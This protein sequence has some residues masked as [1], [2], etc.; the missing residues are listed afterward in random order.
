MPRRKFV[1]IK[2]HG[3]P[4]ISKYEAHFTSEA[5]VQFTKVARPFPEKVEQKWRRQMGR[6]RFQPKGMLAMPS[7][8]GENDAV[9]ITCVLDLLLRIETDTAI[10]PSGF[11]DLLNEE[12]GHLVVFDP[13][14]VGR[15]FTGLLD[16]AQDA[17]VDR[18]AH[19]Q[20]PLDRIMESGARLLAVIDGAVENRWWLGN[21]RELMGRKAQRDIAEVQQGASPPRS[22]ATWLV[23]E[24]V[25]FAVVAPGQDEG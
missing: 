22:E 24:Q 10:H 19:W 3:R 20:R 9:S 1:N 2:R 12:Y 11:T 25:P 5:M 17:M 13:Y 18:P 16:A 23:L 15:I 21:A 4:R 7:R 8:N 6:G 14:T